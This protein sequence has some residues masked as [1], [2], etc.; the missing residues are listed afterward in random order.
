M[1]EH[2]LAQDMVAFLL[3]TMREAG[4][5][6]IV[7]VTVEL[8]E[9]GGESE[10]ALRHGFEEKSEGTPVEGAELVVRTVG[11]RVRCADCAH[12]IAAHSEA[13]ACPSCGGVRLFIA[14][15]PPVVI[16]DVELELPDDPPS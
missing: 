16:R 10:H 15:R 2:K 6:R 3:K 5:Q 13:D 9:F 14:R 1:H 12:E 8:S 11:V 7:R 4:A